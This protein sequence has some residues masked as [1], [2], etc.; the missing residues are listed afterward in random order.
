MKISKITEKIDFTFP[1]IRFIAA[2][3]SKLYCMSYKIGIF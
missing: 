2:V 3:N 1:I